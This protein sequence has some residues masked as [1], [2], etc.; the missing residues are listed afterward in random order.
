MLILPLYLYRSAKYE[1][2]YRDVFIPSY[3]CINVVEDVALVFYYT[4][5]LMWEI[6]SLQLGR[7]CIQVQKVHIY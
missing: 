3:T 5:E 2:E 1:S 6:V 4:D 7:S